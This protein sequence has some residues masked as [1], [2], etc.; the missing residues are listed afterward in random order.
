MRCLKSIIV[1]GWVLG[2]CIARA[3][4]TAGRDQVRAA[5]DSVE[6][7][8]VTSPDAAG[9]RN[10][11]GIAELEREL[12]AERPDLAVLKY[13]LK[14]LENVASLSPRLAKLRT[15]LQGWLVWECLPAS[16]ELASVAES[17]LRPPKPAPPA[18]ATTLVS[19]VMP[20]TDDEL[21][22]RLTALLALLATYAERP[23][24]QVAHAIDGQL[25][26]LESAGKVEPLTAA[27]R[28]YYDHPNVWLDVSE[29]LL[30]P[31]V[32]RRLER[33]ED[34]H[35]VIQDTPLMGRGVLRGAS[36]LVI[37]PRPDRA[38]LRIVF[39]GTLDAHTLGRNGPAEIR[40][41]SLT[42]F[43]AEKQLV[44]DGNG[45]TSVP[46]VCVAETRTLD[47][48]VDAARAG[49]GNRL[50]RRIG[51]RRWRTV[52]QAAEQESAE[53]AEAQIKAAIDREAEELIQRLDRI[54]IA[55]ML[56][57]VGGQAANTRVR[58]RSDTRMLRI[59]AIYG[60]LGAPPGQPACDGRR[61]ITLQ[62]HSGLY[63]R[64]SGQVSASG[65]LLANSHINSLTWNWAD[66]ILAPRLTPYGITLRSGDWGTLVPVSLGGDWLAVEWRR[67][68]PEPRLAE[69]ELPR[70]N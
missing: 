68:T 16:D 3:A 40:A 66:R 55:P 65:S 54:G 18:V 35:D 56:A 23:T 8:V 22:A 62:V 46:A 31:A 32:A 12:A 29:E 51:E 44:L 36:D 58:F 4:E 42:T 48:N 67:S 57:L 49:I 11:L 14:Q 41:H 33:V 25:R 61:G 27:V 50:I 17:I 28:A 59:G 30:S 47:S 64:L 21:R 43:R 38:V 63:H 45:L 39:N 37:V 26:F 7:W 13:T 60:P 19:V 20:V 24:E 9:W 70:L 5:M 52:Q 53:H 34:L 15:A 2:P 69:G 6:H 1:V 10:Y